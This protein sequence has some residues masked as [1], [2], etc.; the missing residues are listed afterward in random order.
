MNGMSQK[1]ISSKFLCAFVLISIFSSELTFGEPVFIAAK[2]QI[3]SDEKINDLKWNDELTHISGEFSGKTEKYSATLA[4]S[5]HREGWQLTRNKMP[6]KLNRGGNFLIE[7]IV[8]KEE[9]ALEFEAIGPK[10]EVERE[11]IVFSVP[12]WERSPLE[13]APKNLFITT[14]LGVSS[15]S[16]KETGVADYSTLALT[17]KL[18]GNYLLVPK[19]LDLGV[20]TYFTAFQLTKSADISARYFG[21]NAR[22]GYILPFV[23]A[24]WA[25]SLYGGWYYTTTFVA[26][27]AFGYKGL[28]GPQIYPSIKRILPNSDVVALYFKFS[29]ISN[30]LSF[31]SASNREIAGGLA[32]VHTLGNGHVVAATLDYSNFKIFL[33]EINSQTNSFTLGAQYGL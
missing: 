7:V 6:V 21:F 11:K 9:R 26:G 27:N 30:G 23:K 29:P 12:Y 15:I 18:S 22:L 16:V 25:I 32:Y 2:V 13:P 20:S 19:V 1:R 31:L 33:D 10:G 28:S 5:Y 24:P 4:G 17:A 3:V 8:T 14:G